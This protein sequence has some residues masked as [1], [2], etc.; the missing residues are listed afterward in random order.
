MFYYASATYRA[1]KVRTIEGAILAV[2][3]VIIFFTLVPIGG[4]IWTGFP[5]IGSWL[6][7]YPGNAGNTGFL[8]ALSIGYAS[9]SIRAMLGYD[10]G[11][12]GES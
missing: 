8:V 11:Y 12:L 3:T 1:F 6:T 7:N 2:T 4:V 10:R 5:V 9:Q